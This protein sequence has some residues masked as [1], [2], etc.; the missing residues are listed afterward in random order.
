M[1]RRNML[2]SAPLT[3]S[4]ARPAWDRPQRLGRSELKVTR[5]GIGCEDIRSED[6]IRR[7]ADLGINYFHAFGNHE[8]VGNELR[9]IRSRVV[10]AAGS[11]KPTREDMLRDLDTQL[12]QFRT[13]YID[14]WYL[15]SKYK[16]ELLTDDLIEGV[17]AAKA[18]GKIGACAV[19]GHGIGSIRSRLDELRGVVSAVMVV[20]NFAT[21]EHRPDPDETRPRTSLPGGSRDDIIQL[22]RSGLGI[23]AMKPLMGGLRFVPGE[24]KPWAESVDRENRRRAALT[25]AL[26]WALNNPHVDCVPVMM[27]SIADLEHNVRA[28][29]TAFTE[30]ERK[31]L[32]LTIAQH[33]AGYCRMCAGCA[34]T[35]RYGLPVPDVLRW[36]MYAEGY[37]NL[38]RARAAFAGMPASWQRVRCA[39]CGACT[40]DC[41]AGSDVRPR[42]IRAQ[43]LLA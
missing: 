29:R 13:D 39:D 8:L 19:A 22:H 17:L 28:A 9:P 37:G 7:A 21:W 2:L 16:P 12:Q 31:Q 43:S 34:G 11:A 32:A 20:C 3:A 4:S 14:L 10:L 26:K 42:L 18:S 35:C 30:S 38:P 15:T 27:T 40:V 6:V 24:R 5:L 25:A 33:G 1:S 36:L 41:R 23:V